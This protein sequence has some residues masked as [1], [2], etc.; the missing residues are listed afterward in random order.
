MAVPTPG[1][2]TCYFLKTGGLQ[3]FP[4]HALT[5]NRISRILLF[6]ST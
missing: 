1:I 2:Q 3:P 4:Q 5:S 6:L